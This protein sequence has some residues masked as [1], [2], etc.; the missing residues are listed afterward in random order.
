M[1]ML[2]DL[3]KETGHQVIKGEYSEA[4]VKKV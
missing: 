4:H 3:P 1:G 2:G